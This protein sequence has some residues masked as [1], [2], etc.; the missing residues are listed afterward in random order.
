MTAYFAPAWVYGGPPRSILASCKGLVSLGEE[1]RVLTT[2]GNGAAD[3]DVPLGKPLDVQGV[4]TWYFPRRSPKSYFRCPDL[5]QALNQQ[6]REFDVIQ[7]HTSLIYLG[8]AVRNAARRAGIPYLVTCHGS[9]D[10]VVLRQKRLKKALYFRLFE[11]ANLQEAAA[12]VALTQEERRQILSLVPGRPVAVV[13]NGMVPIAPESIPPRGALAEIDPALVENPYILFMAR[14]NWKKGLDLLVPAFGR[15]AARFPQ[16]RLV[17][18]GPDEGGYRAVVEG[19]VREHGLEG[20]V[21]LPGLVDGE[22]KLAL[23]G[24]TE[25]FTLPSYS[26]GLPTCVVEALMCGRPV[27]ITRTCYMPEVQ[28]SGVGWVVE[29]TLDGVAEGLA[30]ALGSDSARAERRARAREFAVGTY[31]SDTVARRTRELYRRAIANPRGADLSG[32]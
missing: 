6:A 14:L 7:C 10:P 26:E 2:A 4:E 28:E 16:W 1:V 24:H 23:L 17:L 19:L 5:I 21:V 18:A 31:A 20:R 13:P 30:E 25:L 8:I 3:L 22:R 11:R 9:L 15:L 27:V 12:V 32:F 29:P